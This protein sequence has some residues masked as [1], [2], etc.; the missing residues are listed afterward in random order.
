MANVQKRG[1]SYRIRVSNGHDPVTGTRLYHTMTWK[2]EPGMTEKQIAHELERQKVLFEEKC[3][4]TMVMDECVKLEDFVERW[5]VD[6]ALPNLKKTTVAQYDELLK[7]ILAAMGHIRLC[8]ITPFHLNAFY[9]NLREDGIRVDYKYRCKV[10]FRQLLKDNDISRTKLSDFSGVSIGTIESVMAGNNVNRSTAEKLCRTMEVELDELFEPV[11]AEKKLSPKTLLHYHRCLSAIFSRAVR[12]GV[13]FSNPCERVEPPKLR[14]KEAACL[15]EAQTKA[16][17]EAVEAKAS[18]QY[19]VMVKLMLFSGARRAEVCGLEWGDIDWENDRIHIQRNSLYVPSA[20]MYEDTTKTESSDRVVKLPRTVME[21]LQMQ[22]TRQESDKALVGDAWQ[23]H[24][25]VFTQWNG[26]PINPSSVSTWLSK[27][28]ERNGLP[29]T[30]PHMLRH[31]S[32]TLL[33][34]QGVPL[35]AVS[36]RLGHTLASTTSDIYGHSLRSVEDIA[37]DKLEAML[38]PAAQIRGEQE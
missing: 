14:R 4:R 19:H 21:L 5:R 29:H 15:D 17:L 36:K 3:R 26:K 38:E 7:R 35:K 31:T 13:M 10:D 37:A 25:K 16:L 9:A 11:G 23:E 27:F 24:D 6:Y 1:D 8:D 12:W 33:L 18:L 32:A 34:M 20:G 22:R 2:P 30:T 28:C